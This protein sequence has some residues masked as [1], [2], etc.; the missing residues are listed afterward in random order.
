G[1]SIGGTNMGL[2]VIILKVCVEI[3]PWSGKLV[4]LE[5][6]GKP[7]LRLD[8]KRPCPLDSL[9]TPYDL[10]RHAPLFSDD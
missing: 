3:Y 5:W 7:W 4:A 2:V 1:L 9:W 8:S 10:F 6:E